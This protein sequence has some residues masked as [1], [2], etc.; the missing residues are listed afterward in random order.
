MTVSQAKVLIGVLIT[1]SQLLSDG[2]SSHQTNSEVMTSSRFAADIW[3]SS[4][5]K[6]FLLV[7][8]LYRTLNFFKGF[9]ILVSHENLHILDQQFKKI[10]ETVLTFD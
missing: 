6:Y 2:S 4:M 7:N 10:K 1:S 5:Q 8:F 9:I 3:T